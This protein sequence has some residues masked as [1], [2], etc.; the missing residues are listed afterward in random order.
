MLILT[1]IIVTINNS[2]WKAC[3][4]NRKSGQ[5]ALKSTCC[6]KY[7]WLQITWVNTNLTTY[8]R[9]FIFFFY[10]HF[11]SNNSSRMLKSISFGTISIFSNNFYFKF[12]KLFC[13]FIH[14]NLRG[15]YLPYTIQ[16]SIF[17]LKDLCVWS[18]SCILI[19]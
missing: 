16:T 11:D 13:T 14:V 4:I 17:V 1:N 2:Q 7:N 18:Y 10:K 9:Y 8:S 3:P 19:S 5:K 15:G 6:V 12:W